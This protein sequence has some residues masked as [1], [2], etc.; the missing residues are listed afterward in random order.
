MSLKKYNSQINIQLET[1]RKRIP[2]NVNCWKQ[3]KIIKTN[4]KQPVSY[5]TDMNT[6]LN[7]HAESNGGELSEEKDYI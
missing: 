3:I 2:Q 4:L 5:R 7:F 6:E 1:S